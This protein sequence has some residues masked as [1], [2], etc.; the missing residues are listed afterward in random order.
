[1][2]RLK[3][4]GWGLIFLAVILTLLAVSELPSFQAGSQETN[5]YLVCVTTYRIGNVSVI[6]YYVVPLDKVM[7]EIGSNNTLASLIYKAIDNG[8]NLTYLGSATSP[9]ISRILKAS[10]PECLTKTK[11][12][13]GVWIANGLEPVNN[14]KL[15]YVGQQVMEVKGKSGST[16]TVPTYT[17]AIPATVT[18]ASTAT[19]THTATKAGT[20]SSP[21]QPLFPTT[22]SSPLRSLGSSV[23]NPANA[24]V[25][26][27][28]ATLIGIVIA[29]LAVLITY[30]LIIRK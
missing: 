1:M 26:R 25:N 5:Y 10:I 3:T 29:S 28:V 9:L 19:V 7:E 6:S 12:V 22:T 23:I 2:K 16:L 21:T 11:A 14:I 18:I 13:A 17:I 24:L 8:K 30:E 15:T 4:L 20:I 27:A